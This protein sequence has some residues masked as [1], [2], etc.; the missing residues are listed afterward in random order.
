MAAK[1]RVGFPA[2]IW[3]FL[4]VILDDARSEPVPVTGAELI[5]SATEA[6]AKKVAFPI[7]SRQESDGVTRLALDLGG[8]NLFV[9][10]LLIETP[11]PLFTRRVS[12]A[13]SALSGDRLYEQI[14]ARGVIYRIE[15]NGATDARLDLPIEKEDRGRELIV[16]IENGDD[17]PSLSP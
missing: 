17:A 10:S 14:I 16:S 7:A 8:A 15:T 3:P 5:L 4:R 12:V 9:G 1:S 13:T 2:G 6:P 11:E